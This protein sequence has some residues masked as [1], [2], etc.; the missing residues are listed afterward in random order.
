M[1]I[2]LISILNK[3]GI[4]AVEL[5]RQSFIDNDRVA[6]GKT[7]Q[8]VNYSIEESNNILT[9]KVSGRKDIGTLETGVTAEQYTQNPSTFSD[10]SEWINAR[11]LNRTANSIDRGLKLSGWNTDGANRTG[12]NGG[13]AGI[14]TNPTTAI[15]QSVKD[16]ITFNGKDLIVKEINLKI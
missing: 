9:F 14:I 16:K 12:K 3:E 5:Y 11:G 2:D 6:T 1:L 8:S 13:T 15:V 7:N 4:N 10:L